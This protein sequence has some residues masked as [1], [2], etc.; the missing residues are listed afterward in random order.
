MESSKNCQAFWSI[1]LTLSTTC[2]LKD[3]RD[4][5]KKCIVSG[6]EVSSGLF[7][8]S[9]FLWHCLRIKIQSAVC[10]CYYVKS[11]F[12]H[13]NHY[14]ISH[15]RQQLL[16][17]PAS[18]LTRNLTNH[19]GHIIPSVASAVVI[20]DAQGYLRQICRLTIPVTKG[21]HKWGR[22]GE[23]SSINWLSFWGHLHS[24]C[25]K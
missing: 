6:S 7:Y 10:K 19:H 20:K 18:F 23:V 22:G 17:Q 2:Q 8:C 21:L 13:S 24:H 3:M 5:S 4:C 9:C 1:P 25:P 16:Q 12:W 14:G 11:P 15:I